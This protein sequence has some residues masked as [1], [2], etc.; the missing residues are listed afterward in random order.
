MWPLWSP[1][2]MSRANLP[3][4]RP[5][6][7]S[8]IPAELWQITTIVTAPV[9]THHKTTFSAENAQV[10]SLGFLWG[11]NISP[12]ETAQNSVSA[13]VGRPARNTAASMVHWG[14]NLLLKVQR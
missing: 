2:L 11:R 13:K 12:I 9:E 1:T 5:E 6:K 7:I 14:F 4:T 10:P 8:S 3:P